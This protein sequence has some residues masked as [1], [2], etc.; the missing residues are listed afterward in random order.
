MPFDL[1]M[2]H[3]TTYCDVDTE[4]FETFG[5]CLSTRR[6]RNETMTVFNFH[7]TQYKLFKTYMENHGHAMVHTENGNVFTR[8]RI[9][10]AYCNGTS[11]IK[12]DVVTANT[13]KAKSNFNANDL[14]W[15]SDFPTEED[16]SV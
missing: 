14:S 3:V 15:L 5:E 7:A 8:I 1:F 2:S 4:L 11:I 16:S 13:I 6:I 10:E 12:P 9:K